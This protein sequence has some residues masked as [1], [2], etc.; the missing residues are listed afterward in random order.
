MV[1]MSCGGSADP[2]INDDNLSLGDVLLN[3][4][5]NEQPSTWE[6]IKFLT[7][8]RA[9]YTANRFCSLILEKPKDYHSFTMKDQLIWYTNPKGDEVVGIPQNRDLIVKILD[10]AHATVGHFGDQ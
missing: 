10:Q 6:D 5:S 2:P 9:G 7:Q 1:N 4:T 3:K 8:I